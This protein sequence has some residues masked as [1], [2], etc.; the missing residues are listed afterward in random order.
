MCGA[1]MMSA[2]SCTRL[3]KS[4]KCR[5]QKLLLPTLAAADSFQAAALAALGVADL[6]FR[7]WGLGFGV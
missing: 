5:G 7:V 2:K 6:G 3:L 4:F 1:S